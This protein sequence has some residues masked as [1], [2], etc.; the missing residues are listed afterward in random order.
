[1]PFE[2]KGV[3]RLL[4]DLI[5]MHGGKLPD[6]P[7]FIA[8]HIGCSVRAWNQARAK[9]IEAGKIVA[10]LGII[11]NFRADKELESL[12]TLQE[13]QRENA[14]KP[15][16][17]NGLT[18]A[19][20]QPKPSHTDTDTDTDIFG[21]NEPQKV[22]AAKPPKDDSFDRFWA[23]YP[24]KAGKA[25]ALKAWPKAIA[26]ADPETIILAA[27]RYAETGEVVRGFAKNAQGWLNGERWN[28]EDLKP[29]RDTGYRP[30]PDWM[31]VQR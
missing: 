31:E 22:R 21:S 28:D 7:R 26:K 18:V 19:M 25:D 12:R 11:S 3:Y 20:A 4:L 23:V 2:L 27:S 17:N 24:K 8:G 10:D 29:K 30:I 16:K 14:S 1:M 15:R 5:Y 6:E 13:K 9:L